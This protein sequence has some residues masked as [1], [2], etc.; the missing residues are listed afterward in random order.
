MFQFLIACIFHP[1]I[2]IS[3]RYCSAP[4]PTASPDDSA[5]NRL[6]LP[7]T[8]HGGRPHRNTAP[9]QLLDRLRQSCWS[10]HFWSKTENTPMC[11][12]CCNH[13]ISRCTSLQS[14]T[15]DYSVSIQYSRSSYHVQSFTSIRTDRDINTK[16]QMIH[17]N[18]FPQ[19]PPP[20]PFA[21]W[22]VSSNALTKGANK[23]ATCIIYQSFMIKTLRLMSASDNNLSISFC[24]VPRMRLIPDPR[25]SMTVRRSVTEGQGRGSLQTF[26]PADAK[27]QIGTQ[28]ESCARTRGISGSSG[29]RI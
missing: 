14:E 9:E 6:S 18:A 23:R 15:P 1:T 25:R 12:F 21:S 7:F 2:Y 13:T 24:V 10:C 3:S 22:I 17:G 11:R 29:C 8:S 20:Y 4:S 26:V 28:L 27:G 5:L 19:L 16:F